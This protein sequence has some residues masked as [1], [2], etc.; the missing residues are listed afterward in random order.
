M[1]NSNGMGHARGGDGRGGSEERSPNPP[2]DETRLNLVNIFSFF[3][4][5]FFPL[6]IR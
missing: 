1:A 3:L 6:K 4:F 5:L 2:R